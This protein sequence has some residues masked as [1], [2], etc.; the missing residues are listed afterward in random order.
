MNIFHS[1]IGWMPIM[2]DIRSRSK[3]WSWQS[4]FIRIISS[5][6]DETIIVYS[7][8]SSMT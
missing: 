8:V 5:K 6:V 4:I 1:N 2:L 3:T 7:K